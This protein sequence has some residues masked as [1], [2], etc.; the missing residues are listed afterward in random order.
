MNQELPDVSAGFRKGKGTRAQVLNIH[1]SHKKQENSRRTSTS[2]LLTPLKPLT[3]EGNGN[4][5]QC[6]CLENPRD[7]GAWWAAVCGVAQSRIRLMRLSSSSKTFDYVDHNKLRKFLEL[8]IPDYLICFVRN[9]YAGQ[10]ATEPGMEQWTGFKLGK[11]YVKAVY[12]HPAYLTY[13]QS[14]SCKMPG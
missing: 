14:T 8:G 11:K 3:G 5:L 13:V 4:P 7:G 9:L 1:W 12:C 6:S 10:E 2:A